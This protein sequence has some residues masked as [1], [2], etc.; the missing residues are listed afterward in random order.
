MDFSI[1]QLLV[2][3]FFLLPLIERFFGNKKRRDAE[4][5]E[6][7]E[8]DIDEGLPEMT[9]EETLERLETVLK[10]QHSPEPAPEPQFEPV[11]A[12]APTRP[13]TRARAL[14][15]AV[16]PE[17]RSLAPK[18]PMTEEE[19]QKLYSQFEVVDDTRDEA[20]QIRLD[21]RHLRESVVLNEILM[22]PVALRRRSA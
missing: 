15:A 12:H 7:E 19:R 14:E 20:L 18:S 21:R 1:S 17:F 16:G 6:P 8:V 2:L 3:L 13:K 5:A 4:R 22:R 10:G 9:W 11:P